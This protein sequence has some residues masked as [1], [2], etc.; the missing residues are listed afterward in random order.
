MMMV[1]AKCR[2]NFINK[3]AFVGCARENCVNSCGERKHSPSNLW[4]LS[5]ARICGGGKIIKKTGKL[6]INMIFLLLLLPFT[7]QP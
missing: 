6:P 5:E 2:N 4:Q 3:L 1:E 7:S